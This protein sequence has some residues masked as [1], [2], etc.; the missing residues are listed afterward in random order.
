MH[1]HFTIVSW[2][3]GRCHFTTYF[4]P[5]I[6]AVCGCGTAYYGLPSETTLSYDL[7]GTVIE[8]FTAAFYSTCEEAGIEAE[9]VT[10]STELPPW[11]IK[12]LIPDRVIGYCYHKHNEVTI[13]PAILS[14]MPDHVVK[15]TIFHELVHCALGKKGHD[16]SGL[17]APTVDVNNITTEEVEQAIA[18]YFSRE[19]K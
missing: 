9:S 4:M 19:R 3:F 12:A 7:H 17:M 13:F 15:Y 18:N 11:T 6:L 8:D 16:S 10:I 2:P 1:T 14:G 5:T